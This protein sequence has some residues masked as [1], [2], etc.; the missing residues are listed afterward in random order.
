MPSYCRMALC[1]PGPAVAYPVLT[2]QDTKKRQQKHTEI[3]ETVQQSRMRCSV[4]RNITII[5]GPK[6]KKDT[7]KMDVVEETDGE[8]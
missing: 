4:A 7:K 2:K 3:H 5:L 6:V 1:S 8:M